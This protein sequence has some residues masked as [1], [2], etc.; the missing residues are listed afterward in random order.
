MVRTRNI[1]TSGS[2]PASAARRVATSGPAPAVRIA[3]AKKPDRELGVSDVD[4][5]QLR[6][7]RPAFTAVADH[8]D[9]ASAD[10]LALLTEA[11]ADGE[12][13]TKGIGVGPQEARCGLVHQRH[14]GARPAV[15]GVDG[16]TAPH[17]QADGRQVVGRDDADA[18]Q[19]HVLHGVG[20]RARRRAP[21]S[22]MR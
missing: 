16:P 2:R 9:D 15:G 4:R 7:H 3:T 14:P 19:R 11:R 1:G 18:Q 10:T 20:Q 8:A 5:R 6:R 13:V 17:R 22:E 21:E 12:G